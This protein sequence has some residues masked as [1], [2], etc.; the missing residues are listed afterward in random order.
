MA[1]PPN[2]ETTSPAASG[3]RPPLSAAP[4][5]PSRTIPPRSAPG[6]TTK[7]DSKTKQ[8]DKQ[9]NKQKDKQKDKRKDSTKTT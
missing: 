6:T 5:N 4:R 7:Q 1:V 3:A 2:G 8:K 9:K